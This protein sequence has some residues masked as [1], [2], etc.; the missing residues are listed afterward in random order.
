MRIILAR[1]Y[2]YQ[3]KSSSSLNSI[4]TQKKEWGG[5]VCYRLPRKVFNTS[6]G[7]WLNHKW[8]KEPHFLG[9]WDFLHR[10]FEEN[11][12]KN[13]CFRPSSAWEI[14]F[15]YNFSTY[16]SWLKLLWVQIYDLKQR[17]HSVVSIWTLSQWWLMRDVFCRKMFDNFKFK[18]WILKTSCGPP[19]ELFTKNIRISFEKDKNDFLHVKKR[20]LS[21]LNV[22]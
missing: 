20:E 5:Y 14:I 13:S 21:D 6:G 15:F 3:P 1:T 17:H 22:T 11:T 12:P 9:F 16:L 10:Q 8:L 4:Q 18:S 19:L 2:I 7:K